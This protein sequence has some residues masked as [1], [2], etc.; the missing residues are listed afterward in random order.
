MG[1]RVVNF[2]ILTRGWCYYPGVPGYPFTTLDIL[3]E[4][5]TIIEHTYTYAR[6]A[7]KYTSLPVLFIHDSTQIQ[8]RNSLGNIHFQTS[9]I[10][11]LSIPQHFMTIIGGVCVRPVRGQ[12]I[13]EGSLFYTRQKCFP[14]LFIDREAGE[15][16]C[17][18]A[19]VCLCVGVCVLVFVCVSV[20]SCCF[21]RLRHRGRSRF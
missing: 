10:L 15:I 12:Q 19:S 5:P 14:S 17:L 18:V 13:R 4:L 9:P 20:I 3:L 2:I 11:I 8:T 6:W 1:T 7:H 16:I 21:D